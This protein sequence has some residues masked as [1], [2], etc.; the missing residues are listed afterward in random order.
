MH[1]L[2]CVDNCKIDDSALNNIIFTINQNNINNVLQRDNHIII[3]VLF[4]E[5]IEV[6][7]LHVGSKLYKI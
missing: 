4:K 5:N 6:V 2:E 7:S 3:K 1:S